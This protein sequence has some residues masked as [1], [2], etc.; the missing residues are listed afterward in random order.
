MLNHVSI[1]VRDVA[2]AKRF[3]DAVLRPLGYGCLSEGEGSLGYGDHHVVLWIGAAER[4]VPADEKSGLHFC[5]T[6][7]TRESVKAFHDAALSAGGR[8]NGGPGLRGDYGP[9]YYAAFAIDPDGY[10]I[11]AYC[12]A[13][14]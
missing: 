12:N 8:D 7:P 9:D 6:A 2:R 13:A 14:R 3:Y 5:F 10:R 1:G 4:P 11:E